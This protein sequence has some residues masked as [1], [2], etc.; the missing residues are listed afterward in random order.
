MGN[1]EIGIRHV[2]RGLLVPHGQNLDLVLAVVKRIKQSDNA[3]SAES[4]FSIEQS[5]NTRPTR[6][7]AIKATRLVR[8][9]VMAWI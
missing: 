3:V 5:A 2:C 7:A 1:P 9:E 8:L 4:E 6:A